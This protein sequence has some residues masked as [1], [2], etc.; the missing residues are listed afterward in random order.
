MNNMKK[1]L[2]K[3]IF[4]TSFILVMGACDEKE[5]I[6]P[7]ENAVFSFELSENELVLSEAN[8]DTEAVTVIWSE[9]DFGFNAAISY[10]IHFDFLGG[11]FASSE[12][13]PAGDDLSKV[14]LV[15][16]INAALIDLGITPFEL[17][18]IDVRVEAELSDS[19][20]IMSN[21]QTMS[22][23]A[24][25][26]EYPSLYLVGDATAAGWD[27]DNNNYPMFKD[28]DQNGLN[29]YTGY[30]NAGSV[31]LVETKG[32]WQPQ[33]GKGASDGVLA[34]NPGTQADDPD[35]IAIP[36]AGYYT[37]QVDLINLT[38]SVEAFD[39]SVAPD[40][41]T[42]GVLGQATPTGW[43]S[44]TDMTQSSFDSHIWY[45]N[46]NMNQSE[47][48]DCD[49]GFKFRADDDWAVNWGGNQNPPTLNHGIC[50]LGGKNI[51]VPET[52]EYLMFFN[53]I[54]G[55]YFYIIE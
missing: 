8:A 42:I 2:S 7:D 35:V 52:A 36:S 14:V 29:V 47:G 17:T 3:L 12:Y 40:Y 13:I 26:S 43:G 44:D 21:S 24:Y 9:P 18:D 28:P 16:E 27:P 25:P 50:V 48:G 49:C 39:E 45:M 55:R 54:D 20:S 30:F 22:I 4:L 53:D 51:G 19:S 32:Q 11:D 38:Y 5:M 23:S 6:V 34:G 15:N 37:L 41:L 1:I 33:W 46:L 31:K 10:K